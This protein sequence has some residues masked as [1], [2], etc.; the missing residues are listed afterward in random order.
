MEEI[1]RTHKAR[2]RCV[3][4]R[5][6]DDRP[7]ESPETPIDLAA[8]GER[9]LIAELMLR[10]LSDAKGLGLEGLELP[11][12]VRVKIMAEP[13]EKRGA[14]REAALIKLKLETQ[15]AAIEWI[16]SAVVRCDRKGISFRTAVELTG[17][18]V[19]YV[20]KWARESIRE[21]GVRYRIERGER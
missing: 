21:A 4:V 1:T 18:S 14:L 11:E 13:A 5:Q 19:G 16:E 10:A 8:L 15:L 7:T 9:K 6:L 12:D 3:G 17:A 2:G 20:R